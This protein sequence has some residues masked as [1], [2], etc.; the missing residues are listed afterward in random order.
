MSN[1]PVSTT[2]SQHEITKLD[3]LNNALTYNSKLDVKLQKKYGLDQP[4]DTSQADARFAYFSR[5]Y[6]GPELTISLKESLGLMVP[7][8]R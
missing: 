5:A 1:P 6:D 4:T 2:L 7:M 8:V 3:K